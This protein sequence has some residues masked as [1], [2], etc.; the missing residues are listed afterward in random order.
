M[1]EEKSNNSNA[2]AKGAQ[3]AS[4]VRGAVKTGKAIAAASKG[5]AAGGPYG[6]VAGLIWGNRHL[7][8]KIILVVV[9]IFLLPILFIMMLP[10]MIFGGLK[11]AF[12]PQNPT[13]PILNDSTAIMEN[14]NGITNS[15]SDVLSEALERVLEEIEKDFEASGAVQR[16]IINPH[17]NAP[18]YNANAVVSQ[19]CA[20]KD[21]DFASITFDDMKSILRNVTGE[22]YSYT[23]KEDTRTRVEITVTVD[24]STGKETETTTTVTETWMVYTIVYEGEDYFADNVFHLNA[25]Q[26]KLSA[27][28]AQNLSMFLGNGIS[29]K[30]PNGYE[31]VT[32][33]GDIEFT[34]GQTPVVYFNQLDE[35]YALK[36]YGTDDIGGYGCGPTTMAIVVSSLTDEIVDP[37]KMAK[38]SYEHGYWAAGNGSYHGLIPAAAKA[39]ELPVEG[40]GVDEGQRISDA[41][42]NGKLV[43]AL[44]DEGHF[45][46]SSHFIVLRGVRD[47]KILVADPASYE[48]SEQTWDLSLILEEA[49][50]GAAAGGPFWIIG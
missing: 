5:A 33:F 13:V 12:S 16:E 1:A 46:Q 45:T 27:N 49:R 36:P 9:A 42:S 11:D 14:M 50:E 10:S 38:W 15:V 37:V 18:A 31:A 43:A 48:R 44:M 40:C 21:K 41:L 17:E 24:A 2:L 26:K 28:Y 30:L 35:R 25:E 20:S 22:L 47:G 39:W 32:S 7:V 6:A 23:K 19:F 8:G 29:Q 3:V 34:D 4:T